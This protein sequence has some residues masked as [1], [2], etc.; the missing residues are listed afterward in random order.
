MLGRSIESAVDN[1]DFRCIR[2]QLD[3]LKSGILRHIEE[4]IST[5]GKLLEQTAWERLE[6]ITNKVDD[7]ISRLKPIRHSTQIEQTLSLISAIWDISLEVSLSDEY[8]KG[9]NISLFKALE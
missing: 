4:W 3:T 7:F 9:P 8:S 6:K 2:L 1:K 5:L